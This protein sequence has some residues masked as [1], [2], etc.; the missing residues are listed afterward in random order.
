MSNYH[1][2][3]HKSHCSF[4]L[5]IGNEKD[6]CEKAQ[7]YS[8]SIALTDRNTLSGMIDFYKEARKRKVDYHL[9]IE[10]SIYD[11]DMTKSIDIVL[12]AKNQEG[13]RNLCRLVTEAN[14]NFQAS[15]H[16]MVSL[17]NLSSLSGDLVAVCNDISWE[18]KLYPIF[19]GHLFYEIILMKECEENNLAII[20]STSS[21]IVSLNSIK[22][23]EFDEQLLDICRA[24]EETKIIGNHLVS[25]HDMVKKVVLDFP[26][27]DNAIMRQAFLVAN[28]ISEITLNV[29]LNFQDQL[30]DFPHLLH[31]LNN[32]G[33]GKEELILRIIKKN[34]VFEWTTEYIKRLTYEMEVIT[35]NSRINL[36]DYFL[37]VADTVE[38]CNEEGI[39][40]GC[41][42]GSSSGS[43]VNYGLKITRRDPIER[44]L[45]FERFIS[46]GR[47]EAGSLPDIDL[48]FSH[49]AL[50]KEYWKEKYGH[51][52]VAPI[53]TFQTLQTKSAFKDICS[54]LL[55]DIEFAAVNK[56]TRNLPTK[57]QEE[58]ELQY[59]DRC[60]KE[61]S[62]FSKFVSQ[63]DIKQLIEKLIGHNRQGGRHPCFSANSKI[64]TDEGLK[65][66]KDL[67]GK[68]VKI[69]THNGWGYAEF[70]KQDEQKEVFKHYIKSYKNVPNYIVSENTIDHKFLG[71][72]GFAPLVDIESLDV[73]C[74]DDFD[75]KLVLLGWLWNDGSIRNDL[76]T[77]HVTPE[78]DDE[79]FNI[80][81]LKGKKNY[82][83]KVSLGRELSDALIAYDYDSNHVQNKSFPRQYSEWTIKQKLSFMR[84]MFSANGNTL[85]SEVRIKLSSRKL[86]ESIQIELINLGIQV[87]PKIVINK[88]KICKFTNGEYQCGDSYQISIPKYQSKT[89]SMLIGFV[90]SY[91][92]DR[93]VKALDFKVFNVETL[94]MQDVY[95]F[96]VLDSSPSGYVNGFWAHNCGVAITESTLSDIAPMR[97]SNGEWCL[98]YTGDVCEEVGIIKYDALGLKTLKFIGDCCKEVGIDDP[99]TIPDYDEKTYEA[100][101]DGDTASV[102][103]FNSDIAR[104]LLTKVPVRD[105]TTLTHITSLGRPG[106]MAND[107]H[108]DFIELANGRKKVVSPHSLLEEEL[109]DNFGLMIYQENVMKAAQILGGFTVEEADK[110]RKAMG[111]KKPE[112]L[113]KPKYQFIT[114]ALSKKYGTKDEME[115]IWELMATFA[116][117]GFSINHADSYAYIGY[118]CQYLKTHYP[119]NWWKSCLANENDSDRVKEYYLY[120]KSH[121]QLPS[122]NFSSND[123]EI[124]NGKIQMPLTAV[125]FLGQKACDNIVSLQPFTSFE[126]FF[127]RVNKSVVN[128]RIMRNLILG[129]AFI[130]IDT[131]PVQQLIDELYAFKK[132][133][134]PDDFA[135]LSF[136]S[137]EMHRAKSLS[138]LSPNYYD[139]FYDDFIDDDLYNLQSLNGL[140][141]KVSLKVGGEIVSIKNRKT[142]KDSKL[143]ITFELENDGHIISCVVFPKNTAKCAEFIEKKNIVKVSGKTSFFGGQAQVICDSVLLI[144]KQE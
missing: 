104:S 18:S 49:P 31:P 98:E 60:L 9:G 75:E 99:W 68:T 125:M 14:R 131:R 50:V 106:P 15:S 69:L 79:L 38:W 23:S 108:L 113:E 74:H 32:D 93:L 133:D 2:L 8:A 27:I 19:N 41:G 94:G 3:H 100:F 126:D 72:S 127:N 35:K 112:L 62:L 109:S 140:E 6:I 102:F 7:E 114:H 88:G 81:I 141:E 107:V 86:V 63:N 95:D 71:E 82:K 24:D 11:D 37:V 78:K 12:L 33:C 67:D 21:Y 45:P 61:S 121:I 22:T 123:Y 5:A 137:I 115:H 51:D 130:D 111:K 85:R 134:I 65:S 42:R 84:G 28:H 73:S 144:T 55:P 58:T 44:K 80:S 47:I 116:G 87:S 138:F 70:F 30:V 89:F 117:Y 54:K 103:Q 4:G 129:N 13:Y 128:V 118:V 110:V 135:D 132:V 10:L 29:E 25:V 105:V 39:Y 43:L 64:L 77:L 120:A 52:R 76:F 122:V 136:S 40:V 83:R 91:K 97:Y 119:L 124:A 46:Q 90:Q 20:K 34:N 101:Q 143:M 17:I 59:F 36:S 26:Y 1:F 66:F 53:G 57:D 48:D 92:R 139:I 56:L 16:T 96:T 142:K